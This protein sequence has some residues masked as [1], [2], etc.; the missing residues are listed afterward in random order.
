MFRKPHLLSRQ[1]VVAMVLALGASSVA[2]ADDSSM[3]PPIRDFNNGQSRENLNMKAQNPSPQATEPVGAQQKKV[4]QASESKT[5]SVFGTTSVASPAYRS[6]WTP[7][8]YNQ[9]PGQ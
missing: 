3:N 7:S 6:P 2:L 1:L 8:W 9:F 5:R 4:A